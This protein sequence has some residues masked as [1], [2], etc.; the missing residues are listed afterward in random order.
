MTSI[1]DSE[2]SNNQK[3]KHKDFNIYLPMNIY[4]S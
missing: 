4:E 2:N 3:L 1:F